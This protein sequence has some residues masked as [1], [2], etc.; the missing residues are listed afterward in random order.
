MKRLANAIWILT[1]IA[2]CSDDSLGTLTILE[3]SVARP[4]GPVFFD[5][6]RTQ[7]LDFALKS[8]A[9]TT[10]LQRIGDQ[11]VFILNET[12]EAGSE[13]EYSIVENKT[14][15]FDHVTVS[16]SST[17]ISVKVEDQ[18]ALVY[19]T[20]IIEPPE[21][22]PSYYRRSGFI[23]PAYTPKGNIVTDGF[24][25]GHRHQHGIFSA[26]VNTEFQGRKVDFW[27]Q[28]NETG[29]VVFDTLLFAKSGPVFG[30]FRTRQKHLNL[31]EEDTIVVLS[32]TWR[33]RTY[34]LS[35]YHIWDIFVSQTNVSDST[36]NLLQYHYGGMAFRGSAEWNDTSAVEGP[37]LVGPG[38]GG[39]L[40]SEGKARL[41]ANHT[42]PN[43]VS[44][45]GEVGG[46]PVNLVA[47]SHPANPR[48]P[49][50]VRIHP[51]MPYFCYLPVVEEG[52]KIGPDTKYAARY[53]VVVFDGPPDENIINGLWYSYASKADVEVVWN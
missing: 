23:H 27:N 28:Q 39:F 40:T 16:V 14:V 10:A 26:W 4:S 18:D 5:L 13:G 22:E 38:N 50:F 34:N 53:R 51:T 32:E 42:R 45:F 11:W 35:D 21:G 6:G 9:R 41:E 47:M 49:Q 8:G 25:V 3:T 19:N 20:A 36:L 15:N 30:E 17:D 24:P 46:K 43:W 33:V 31:I 44:M 29:T 7:N 37:Q 1:L 2:G 12:I 52:M 48:A